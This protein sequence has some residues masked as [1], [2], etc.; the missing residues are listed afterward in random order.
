[1][2]EAAPPLPLDSERW[3]SLAQ[4]YGPSAA[5]V[6]RLLDHL[7]RVDD[8]QRAELWFGLWALLCPD[9][10]VYPASY[11]AAPHLV[12]FA[13]R[14]PLADRTQAL[15]LAAAI[16]AGR[17][18]APAPPLPDDVAAA[19]HAATARVAPLVARSVG[20]PWDAD[21]AQVLAS[22]LA[23]AK[24]HPRFGMAALALEPVVACPVCG[25]P[26]APAGWGG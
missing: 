15:H 10:R 12:A 13:E 20:E 17:R 16:E 1:M 7:E 2:S 4:A 14:R 8:A 18:A 24:G 9:G 23:I 25:A 11:A 19:Y 26:H 5:D 3:A 21:T 6:A 22:V